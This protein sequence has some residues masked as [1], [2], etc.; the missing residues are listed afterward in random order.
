[1]DWSKLNALAKLQIFQKLDL[2]TLVLFPVRDKNDIQ[3]KRNVVREKKQNLMNQM[4]RKNKAVFHKNTDVTHEKL[5]NQIQK[6]NRYKIGDVVAYNQEHMREEYALGVVIVNRNT[7]RKEIK[8]NE[9]LSYLKLP[10]YITNMLKTLN[11]SDI[12]TALK[13]QFKVPDNVFL[14][15]KDDIL[16]TPFN[17][18]VMTNS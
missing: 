8:S 9:G 15:V 13:K 2:K 1:M 11:Y 12:E 6:N 14:G 7:M 4:L 18:R 16:G 3:L 10:L 17:K 5:E